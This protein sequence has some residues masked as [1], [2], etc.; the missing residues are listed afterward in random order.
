MKKIASTIYYIL[1][2]KKV[3]LQTNVKIKN[4]KNKLITVKYGKYGQN[5]KKCKRLD[6]GKCIS[7]QIPEETMNKHHHSN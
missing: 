5:K 3:F 4:D 6:I 1:D 2:S 7:T